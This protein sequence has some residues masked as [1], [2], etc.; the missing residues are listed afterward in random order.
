VR[1]E[2]ETTKRGIRLNGAGK[3][4]RCGPCPQC[5]GED[6]FSI[7]VRKQVFHCRG[8]GAS[9]DSIAL[10]QLIDGTDFVHAVETL[11]RE[12]PP[13]ANGKDRADGARKVVAEIYPYR[14]AEGEVALVVER[15]EYQ[16]PDGS[17]VMKG[18][19][20]KKTFRQKRPDPDRPGE[21]IWDAEGVPPLIYHL[22]AI[23]EA[24][25]NEQMI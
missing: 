23:T 18:G 1:I 25:A 13:K 20:R 4:E 14:D 9:G 2:D 7:N 3:N 12:P 24:I 10:V 11:T 15:I 16:N 21:W 17:F 19:K 5:G 22:P 8:C 6:R